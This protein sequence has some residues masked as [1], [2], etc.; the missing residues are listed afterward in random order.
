MQIAVPLKLYFAKG[1]GFL[2][3]DYKDGKYI[4]LPVGELLFVPS[5]S[6]RYELTRFRVI[7]T[8]EP[9]SI[10]VFA[11]RRVDEDVCGFP[12]NK[13][14]RNY[15]RRKVHRLKNGRLPYF[16]L[17]ANEALYVFAPHLF[18]CKSTVRV[19]SFDIEV[20][21]HAGEFAN[22]DTDPIIALGIYDG[23]R[24]LARYTSGTEQEERELLLWFLRTIAE[25]KPT[26]LAG[27]YSKHFDLRYIYERCVRLD[28]IDEFERLFLATQEGSSIEIKPR[29]FL[30][31]DVWE[32]VDKDQSLLG[33]LQNKKLETVGEYFGYE[34]IRLPHMN[35]SEWVGTKELE[36]YHQ[37]DI[38]LTYQ[39]AMRYIDNIIAL[40]E[41]MQVPLDAIMNSYPAFIP[42]I[43]TLR[44]LFKKKVIGLLSNAQKYGLDGRIASFNTKKIW[45]KY[46]GALIGV[47]KKGYFKPVYKIDFSSF[48]PN[49]L[50]TLN[51]GPDTTK[52]IEVKDYQDNINAYWKDTSLIIEVPDD[53]LDKT[54]V[55]EID[56][57]SDSIYRLVLKEMYNDRKTLKKKLSK[58]KKDSPEY[59]A[60]QAAQV[61]RK[62]VMNSIYGI[63]G[64]KN[65]KV[66]D[67]SIAIAVVGFCRDVISFVINKLGDSVIEYD[68][69]GVYI[70]DYVDV[71]EIN[72]AV[73]AYIH[74]KYGIDKENIT[75]FMEQEEYD[76]MYSIAMK[77]YV[78]KDGDTIIFKGSALASPK[79]PPIYKE[80]LW[81][82]VRV[83]FYGEDQSL[84]H[85]YLD[86]TKFPVEKFIMSTS[87][88][89]SHPDEYKNKN[90]V[91]AR[92][93]RQL[94]ERHGISEITHGT[95]VE[96]VVNKNRH[97]HLVDREYDP[98]W[99]DKIDLAYEYYSDK[100]SKL[101]EKFGFNIKEGALV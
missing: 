77:S 88:S 62:V 17:A 60:T 69:D 90:S 75:T 51:A 20:L 53:N 41:Y 61:A 48:Y 68:T 63:H 2:L 18:N 73:A 93:A 58:L 59:K 95:K 66:G 57:S 101:L 81:D 72:E 22:Y 64:N 85:K 9:A 31:Y 67:L 96:Y 99:K 19:A 46:Q 83:I 36:R 54:I 80:C 30:H 98:N 21:S 97:Y 28:L 94:M 37:N 13:I 86:L 89:K 82:I 32:S 43:V 27:Y 42:R 40:A 4:K 71:N 1:R 3:T 87:I 10:C 14:D 76:A 34:A 5:F 49:S 33:K 45:N 70:S 11:S 56:Q 25:V 74:E 35:M 65:S 78:L 29:G 8:L 6:Q 47:K 7:G 16:H 23:E 100:L 92:L 79:Q 55:V 24:L 26:V 44:G 38:I 39:L 12:I 50:I 15:L 84:L 91:E 52:I